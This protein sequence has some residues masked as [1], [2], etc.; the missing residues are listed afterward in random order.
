MFGSKTRKK[1]RRILEI[2]N[3]LRDSNLGGRSGSKRKSALKKELSSLGGKTYRQEAREDKQSR[4]KYDRENIKKNR[5]GRVV[6]YKEGYDPS[7][8]V[9][10]ASSTKSSK[11]KSKSKATMTGRE[12]AQQMARDRI[13]AKKAGTYKKPKTAQ[14]LAKERLAKKNKKK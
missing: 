5:R 11:S 3:T 7:K 1:N 4:R 8:G 14:E 9:K 6:G 10:G 13:A 12:R 2:K